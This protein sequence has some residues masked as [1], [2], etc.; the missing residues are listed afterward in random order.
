MQEKNLDLLRQFNL[1]KAKDGE[2]ICTRD[3]RRAKFIAHLPECNVACQLVILLEGEDEVT[4]YYDNGAYEAV[5]ESQ[6]DI[7]MAPLTWLEGKPVYPGDELWHKGRQHTVVAHRVNGNGSICE[8]GM[9]KGD[10]IENLTWPKPKP[11]KEVE[12]LGY[13][14]ENGV[15]VH[16]TKV[17]LTGL[18]WR[19][20]PSEDK[21]VMVEEA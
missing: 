7:F 4:K 17:P 15:L 3:G 16:V 21:T 20:V 19:R 10:F 5:H 14:T 18:H 1:Q 13:I 11:L 12:L 9:G 8:K 6:R 2:P